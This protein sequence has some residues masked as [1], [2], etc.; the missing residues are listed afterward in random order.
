ME[1]HP[2]MNHIT[3]AE[4]QEALSEY[5]KAIPQ[6]IADLDSP[7]HESIPQSVISLKQMSVLPYIAGSQLQLLQD[8]RI[9]RARQRSRPFGAITSMRQHQRSGPGRIEEATRE[10]YG[11]LASDLSD[12]S[13]ES[14]VRALAKLKGSD[15]VEASLLLSVYA[16]AELP[17][18]SMELRK[19]SQVVSRSL[20]NSVLQAYSLRE[21]LL[22]VNKVATLRARL[23]EAV[24][25]TD[26]EK[27]AYV[28]GKRRAAAA[29]LVNTSERR[30]D[31]GSEDELA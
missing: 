30:H 1:L 23:G 29:K 10:A 5:P 26:V 11:L 20:M 9:G 12:S 19:W 3:C 17:Y 2:S 21:Y 28:L 27:V 15:V 22:V 4:F 24:S 8:W 13:V 25:A 16:P 7:R 6:S 18:F 14:A 31:E